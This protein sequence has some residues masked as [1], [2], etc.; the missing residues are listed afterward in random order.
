MLLLVVSLLPFSALQ[1]PASFCASVS[2][3]YM[4]P[5]AKMHMI[6]IFFAVCILSFQMMG[7]GRRTMAKS[8]TTL[9]DD[10]A[11][12][13]PERLPQWPGPSTFQ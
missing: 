5:T 4:A 11:T 6:L 10:V 3:T 7:S 12:W 2:S 1:N 9:I 8:T 13:E